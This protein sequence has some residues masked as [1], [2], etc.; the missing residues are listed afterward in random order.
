MSHSDKSKGIK[1][2]D[3]SVRDSWERITIEVLFNTCNSSELL[4]A[5]NKALVKWH[6]H[7]V[8]DEVEDD[9]QEAISTYLVITER[10]DE[11]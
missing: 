7:N 3:F 11:S 10:T 8:Y 1:S 4:K 5:Q 9:G 6:Q 2:I